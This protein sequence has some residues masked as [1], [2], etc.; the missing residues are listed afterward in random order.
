MLFRSNV[1][2]AI[3]DM[4]DERE[5]AIALERQETGRSGASFIAMGIKATLLELEL[6]MAVAPFRQAKNDDADGK[7]EE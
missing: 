7:C 2:I 6:R 1:A 5:R 3:V 4:L